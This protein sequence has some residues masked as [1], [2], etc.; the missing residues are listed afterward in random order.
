MPNFETYFLMKESDI[1]LYIKTKMPEFF[2]SA[3][4]VTAK[5]IG[6]GNLNYVY[7]LAD[8]TGKSIIVKQA[9]VALR[10]S[11][12]MKISTDR[13]RI[14][15]EILLLQAKYAGNLVPKIYQYDTVMCACIMEDL[16][17]YQL[18][19]YALMEHK[20][21]PRFADDISTF[22]VNTLLSTT[23]II[24]EH[25]Q[26]KELVKSFINPQLCEIT[27]D[28]VYTEPYND[29]NKRNI[30]NADLLGFVKKELYNDTA[31]HLE[32]AKLKF[33]FMNNAQALL[34]GD[35]HTGSIFVKGDSTKIFDPEFAFFGPIGYDAGNVIANLF[36]AWNNG[37]AGGDNKFC[38]WVLK[39]ACDVIDMFK[40]KSLRFIKT[41]ATDVMAKTS[42]FAEYYIDAII[43]D[44]AACCGVELIRRTVGMA[45]VKDITTIPGKEK[46]LR[47][48]K[49]NILCA[50]NCILNRTKFKTGGDFISALKT[51][52]SQV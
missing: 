35:L 16:S 51:A 43:A 32:A 12:K 21:F 44:T 41:N 26:K 46:R 52:A 25:K 19:R 37:N 34:H 33:D 28:L 48:E 24:M 18:M 1:P 27:E 14:E 5:E 4:K 3:A 45:Q 38:E 29:C 30:V 2:G 8:G 13:N 7:R 31:L 11:E 20:T 50:K 6:D 10:I 22:M 49:I 9:G 23:D 47:A 36:F 40:E 15:S 39:T 42:G 17:D